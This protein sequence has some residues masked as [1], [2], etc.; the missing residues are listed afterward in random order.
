VQLALILNWVLIEELHV[1]QSNDSSYSNKVKKCLQVKGVR[2]Y[3]KD[4]NIARIYSTSWVFDEN[5]HAILKAFFPNCAI[6]HAAMVSAAI[7]L[8]LTQIFGARDFGSS[9]Y[10]PVILYYGTRCFITF[11]TPNMFQSCDINDRRASSL[12]YVSTYHSNIRSIQCR[13][14]TSKY[15]G[16]AFLHNLFLTK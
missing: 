5:L 2:F 6:M 13:A 8:F 14:L 1:L 9:L 11:V 15:D 3:W 7:T 16:V 4:K 10:W 12:I